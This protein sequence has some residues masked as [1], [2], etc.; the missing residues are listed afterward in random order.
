MSKM[1]QKPRGTRDILPEE[2]RIFD[3][4][5]EMFVHEAK[6]SGY[7]K[8][9]TPI[10]E[11]TSLFT[12]GVGRETD[13]VEKEMYTFLDKSKNSITLRPEGTAPVVRAYLENGMQSLPKPVGLYYLGSMFRY[14]RPQAGRYREFTQFGVEVLATSESLVDA[15]LI[16]MF[17][18]V[19][20]R[21]Q[22]KDL[23]LQINSIGCPSC[24]PKYKKTLNAYISEQSK[25]LCE[26]CLRR[27]KSNPLRILDCKKKECQAI[28]EE[29]PAIVNNLCN[30]CHKHFAQV[31][32]WLDE[33]D[34]IYEINP[35]LVRG[36]E[37]YTKTVFEVWT[38]REGAQNA[39]GGGGRYDGL[40]ELLGGRKTAAVG[41]AA[42]I[43]RIVGEM[44]E[45]G[46]NPEIK[47]DVDVFVAQLGE[48]AKKK[49]FRLLYDLQ[50]EGIGAR[51]GLD[52]GGISEQLK[53]ANK[54]GVYFTLIIGQKEAMSNTVIIKDMQSGT[55]ETYPIEKV[56]KEV[57]KRLKWLKD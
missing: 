15:S 31:L 1:F 45:Q 40:V 55:Q 23:S 57:K 3:Y 9:N 4:V 56:V 39:L 17:W 14:D 20:E 19:L 27:A 44:K 42:G 41:F 10:F 13:I 26:D 50:K 16:A 29:A 43:D 46:I 36:L 24:R 30:D 32:E 22:M 28:V 11:D 47:K 52:K 48:V 21:L 38:A 33:L 8:I 34:I 2:S 12:R 53:I 35:K 49:G 37:Y 54:H 18:R 7:G 6:K 5:S 25:R 51:A